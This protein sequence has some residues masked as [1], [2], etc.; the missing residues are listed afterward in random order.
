MLHSL[1]SLA[2]ILISRT[3]T[4]LCERYLNRFKDA[5]EDYLKVRN[6]SPTVTHTPRAHTRGRLPAITCVALWR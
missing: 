1:I 2:M 6:L 3:R 5:E 4:Q